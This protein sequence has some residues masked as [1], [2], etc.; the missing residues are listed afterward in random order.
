M[1]S[2]EAPQ[3]AERFAIFTTNSLSRMIFLAVSLSVSSLFRRAIPMPTIGGSCDRNVKALNG[4]RLR[5]LSPTAWKPTR[6]AAAP[7]CRSTIYSR[8][9]MSGRRRRTP[10]LCRHPL[11]LWRL[12]ELGRDEILIRDR[13]GE[14]PAFLHQVDRR[15]Q[16]LHRQHAGGLP[17]ISFDIILDGIARL[18]MRQ[19]RQAATLISAALSGLASAQRT[20]SRVARMNP[21]NAFRFLARLAS[22]ATSKV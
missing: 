12:C 8:P 2:D 21:S 10:P 18:V 5:D 4:A 3:P 11:T 16:R 17:E 1:K 14:L 15:R 19:I 20:P 22:V 6:L 7:H 9:L 13:A